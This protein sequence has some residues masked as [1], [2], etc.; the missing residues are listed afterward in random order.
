MFE[1]SCV[2]PQQT[3]NV[4]FFSLSSDRSR[5]IGAWKDA[6][7]LSSGRNGGE[8]IAG[9]TLT[10]YFLLRF[11]MIVTFALQLMIDRVLSRKAFSK[12][13]S[14]QGTIRADIA[15]S[16]LEINQTRLLCLNAAHSMDVHGNKNSRHDIALAK[17]SAPRMARTVIDRAIQAHG[18][19]GLSQ[20]TPLALLWSW[21]R[22]LQIAD[23][24]D[25]VHVESVAKACLRK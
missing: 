17:I 8:G 5:S 15:L 16:R 12:Y 7:L 3:N 9:S 4:A 6:S 21:A 24:P 22:V 14:E 18:G 23:G 11:V 10:F 20:D 13:L 19:M 1:L 25:E 2:D